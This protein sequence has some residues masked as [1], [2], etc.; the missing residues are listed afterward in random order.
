[1]NQNEKKYEPVSLEKVYDLDFHTIYMI[2]GLV[3]NGI[4]VI[5]KL[6]NHISTNCE[7]DVKITL[8]SGMKV[9]GPSTGLMRIDFDQ[10]S[11]KD[12]FWNILTFE[13]N[14]INDK[15]LK[16]LIFPHSS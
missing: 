6:P 11:I 14:N 16:F 12:N 2:K 7:T 5:I 13:T 10:S 1:M 8:K 3:E 15:G 9:T 4:C